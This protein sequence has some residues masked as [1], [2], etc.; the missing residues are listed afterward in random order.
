MQKT[1][2]RRGI[3]RV[4]S[5][6][7]ALILGLSFFCYTNLKRAQKSE[8]QLE[9]QYLKNIDD[10]TTH[11]DNI[12]NTLLKLLYSG[13]PTT[14]TPLASKLWRETGFAKECLSN[15][16]VGSLRLEN[17]YKFLSQA[18]DYTVSLSRQLADGNMISEEERENLTTLKGYTHSFLQEVLA[19][20]DGV[21]SGSLSFERVKEDVSQTKDQVQTASFTEGFQEFEEGFSSYP[22]LIYDGPFSDNLLE[23]EPEMV[24]SAKEVSREEAKSSVAKLLKISTDELKDDSD[25]A[26]K[27]PS[28]CFYSDNLNVAV[29][30]QGGYLSYLVNSRQ[31]GERSVSEEDC[32]QAAAR[33]LNSMGYSSMKQTYYEI[34]GN[35]ITINYAATQ[36]KVTCYPDLMKVSVAMDTGEVVRYDARGYLTN[37][38]TRSDLAPTI[39]QGTLTEK[40]SPLLTIQKTSLCV[41]PS[42]G[43]SEKFCYELECISEQGD[44]VLVY[45]NA[46]TGKEEQLLILYI[47]ENGTLTL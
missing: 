34:N 5:F 32:L 30:K 36:D 23:R 42:D 16:P 33:F 27:M 25:E 18:G 13:S 41:I 45:I 1:F 28:Y 29:T 40:I 12:D 15:L 10:L 22:T 14:M 3:V 47:D 37:H 20:Q 6:A 4:V 26:G 2:S 7:A 19:V 31:I 39:E 43:T 9:Y 21:R 11:M 8:L 17:T 46:Q 24:K 38:K 44:H 35:L